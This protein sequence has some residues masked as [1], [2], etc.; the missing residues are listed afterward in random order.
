MGLVREE[1]AGPKR[2][3]SPSDSGMHMPYDMPADLPDLISDEIRVLER[4]Q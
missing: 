1:D 2:T 4:I 3:V